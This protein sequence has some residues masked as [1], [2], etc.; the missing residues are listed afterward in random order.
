MTHLAL[1][2]AQTLSVCLCLSSSIVLTGYTFVEMTIR[3]TKHFFFFPRGAPQKADMTFRIF[4]SLQQTFKLNEMCL[5]E[6]LIR[7]ANLSLCLGREA[8]L[9]LNHY[10]HVNCI[11]HSGKQ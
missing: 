10:A 7:C 9:T 4:D 6:M 3:V 1:E 2:G 5:I 8:T 11:Y